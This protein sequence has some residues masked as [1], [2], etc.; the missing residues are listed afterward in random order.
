MIPNT[1]PI[2][3]LISFFKFIWSTIISSTTFKLISI[4]SR[5][6]F[7]NSYTIM[8][9]FICNSFLFFI[10]TNRVISNSICSSRN[11]FT[12]SKFCIFNI[13]LWSKPNSNTTMRVFVSF[14]R[15]TIYPIIYFSSRVFSFNSFITFKTNNSICINNCPST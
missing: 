15:N 8:R 1:K 14:S 2:K 12:L 10:N 11:N 13:I 6:I 3:Y 7:P 5:R 4:S 9:M